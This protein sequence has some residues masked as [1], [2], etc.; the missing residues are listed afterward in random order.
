MTEKEFRKLVSEQEVTK[1]QKE[2][3]Q[4]KFDHIKNILDKH[5]NYYK[6]VD[7]FKAGSF[8]K[9]TMLNSNNSYDMA[10][11]VE[12]AVKKVFSLTN[13]V[14]TNEIINAI[15][16]EIPEITKYSDIKFDESKNVIT[17]KLDEDTINIIV[18][19]KDI[20][21][22]EDLPTIYLSE[23]EKK[24]IQF[25][26]LANRDYTYFRNTVQIIKYY[27]DEQ[28][29]NQISGYILEV[30]LYYSLRE[31]CFDTRY[32]DYLNAFLKGLDDFIGGK[33]IEVYDKMYQELN[34]TKQE[35]AKKGFMVM[36]VATGT[37]NLSED[38]NEIKI[39]DYRKL[40]KAIS[41]LVD[42]KSVKDLGT[43][44]VKLNVTPIKNN[45]GTYSW[46]YK[47]E[48][49]T[50][51][52]GGGNYTNS[53][54]DTYTAIYKAMLKG[55]KAI[56]DNNLNRKQVEIISPKVDALTSDNGLS[57]ENNARR[58]NVLAFIENN[59]IKITK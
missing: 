10:V 27:R 29:V 22:I 5:Q 20:N 48:D 13:K 32:E 30:L 46:N 14:I 43:G 25:V 56:I 12:P 7:Y 55:L 6:L 51:T 49:T 19:Y 28:K 3:I 37:I 38:V 36:D 41:K 34:V 42:T 33:K 4:E 8:A 31:Y 26:E 18:Y 9:G 44:P 16:Y 2:K 58:K 50:I 24:R 57:N 39:G 21:G 52:G 59:Q 35:I 23:N 40:K 45:D 15:I 54:E 1:I 17:F 53:D 11:V 47:I